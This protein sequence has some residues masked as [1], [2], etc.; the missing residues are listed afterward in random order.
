MVVAMVTGV[1]DI[2]VARVIKL[3]LFLLGCHRG[4]CC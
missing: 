4:S 2:L 1:V 3:L